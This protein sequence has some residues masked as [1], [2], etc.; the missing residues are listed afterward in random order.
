M[1]GKKLQP[2]TGPKLDAFTR[3]S[4]FMTGKAVTLNA[5]EETILHRWIYTD[6]VMRANKLTTDEICTDLEKKFHIHKSTALGDIRNT[7]KLFAMSR[8]I[9]KQYVGHL[10]LERINKDIEDLRERLFFQDGPVDGVKVSRVPDGKEMMA[11]ARLHEAYNHALQNMPVEQ[12]ADKMPPPIFNFNLV[13]GEISTTMTLSES[14]E[15]AD[16][17]LMLG[18]AYID[19]EDLPPGD[20]E[21]H[22]DP[23]E[24]K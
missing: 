11:L 19:H 13:A 18:D 16:K 4:Q 5:D 14:M 17:M 1:A 24:P 3:I 20:G 7:Q 12:K 9:N 2:V 23:S 21:L 6:Q 22:S 10:H 8:S 15:E